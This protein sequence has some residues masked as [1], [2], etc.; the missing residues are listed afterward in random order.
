[1]SND[2]KQSMTAWE[3]YNANARSTFW[4]GL[5]VF[6]LLLVAFM[7]PLVHYRWGRKYLSKD[8]SILISV[9]VMFCLWV[10]FWFIYPMF[11]QVTTNVIFQ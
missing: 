1:M 10:G 4:T 5:I 9:L 7:I 6:L 11:F 2:K 3:K 8:N